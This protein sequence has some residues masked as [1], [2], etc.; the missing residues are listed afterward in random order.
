MGGWKRIEDQARYRQRQFT[1]TGIRGKRWY[2]HP[3]R[4]GNGELRRQPDI[5][6]RA[7]GGY[8][9]S[10]VVIDGISVG[11]ATSLHVHECTDQPHD[12]GDVRFH[13]GFTI[14]ASAG[15]GGTINPSG[16]VQ[17][18]PG[19]NQTFTITPNTGYIISSV[20]VD[21]VNRGRFKQPIR[22]PTSKPT[23]RSWR[24]S[25]PTPIW[26]PTTSSTRPGHDRLRLTANAKNGTLYGNCTWATGLTNNALSIPGGTGDYVGPAHGIVSGLTNFTIV[27]WVK[28]TSVSTNMRIFDFGTS[29]TN[30]MEMTPK[31]SELEWQD[32]VLYQNKLDDRA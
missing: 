1:I 18:S 24:H 26:W 25:P 7:N 13:G 16:A 29:T 3:E 22:S 12:L 15:S 23:T 10:N 6:Y 5:H 14:T 17:V 20:T 9:I 2:Y 30:Y 4:S 27:T 8:A 11:V 28:L 32:R 31:H 19:A 21:S